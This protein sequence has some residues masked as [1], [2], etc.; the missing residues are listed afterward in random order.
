MKRYVDYKKC[1]KHGING[2][3]AELSSNTIICG[4]ELTILYDDMNSD[5]FKYIENESGIKF[6]NLQDKVPDFYCIP[7]VDLFAEYKNGYFGTL[8]GSID[9]PVALEVI[10]IDKDLKVYLLEF[11]SISF[12]KNLLQHNY[13]FK[14]QKTE[15]IIV[16]EF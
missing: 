12:I 6:M 7:K 9:S 5:E 10:Y 4:T 8:N 15:K 1:I 3:R 11:D 2:L 14:K 16:V 13:I